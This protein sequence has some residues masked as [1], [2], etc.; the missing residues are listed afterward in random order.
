M[1]RCPQDS[2]RERDE[3]RE[4]RRVVPLPSLLSVRESWAGLRAPVAVGCF[5]RQFFSMSQKQKW[6]THEFTKHFFVALIRDRQAS[7]RAAV[8]I[9]N[10]AR[11]RAVA[12]YN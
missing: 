1:S 5:P 11:A 3:R 6:K 4:P 10:R 7:K 9:T 12:G 8:R 2:V